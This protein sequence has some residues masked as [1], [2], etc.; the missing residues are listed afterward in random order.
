MPFL[1]TAV[2]TVVPETPASSG[3]DSTGDDVITGLFAVSLDSLDDDSFPQNGELSGPVADTT[4][5]CSCSCPQVILDFPDIALRIL[6][7]YRTLTVTSSKDYHSQVGSLIGSS[8]DNGGSNAFNG[9]A[10]IGTG[11]P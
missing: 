1:I 3:L 5:W 2:F 4:A 7:D 11:R 6:P 9:E 8:I 10:V